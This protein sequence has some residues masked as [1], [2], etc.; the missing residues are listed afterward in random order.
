MKIQ[1]IARSAHAGQ[2]RRDGV[3]PYINHPQEVAS[4]FWEGTFQNEIAWLHDVLEDSAITPELLKEFGV[5][6]LVIKAVEYLTH[7]K[8]QPYFEYISSLMTA[9]RQNSND[10]IAARM[11]LQVK[12]IDIAVN[13]GDSPTPRQ[14]KK[15]AG[16]LKIIHAFP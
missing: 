6:T 8:G 15:Y 9:T 4:H 14:V 13:L 16:A 3:T 12:L 7:E 5:H 2:F 10:A 11:A 1:E